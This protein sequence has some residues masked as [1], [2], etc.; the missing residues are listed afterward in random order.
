MQITRVMAVKIVFNS[1]RIACTDLRAVAY[2]HEVALTM[3]SPRKHASGS[4]ELDLVKASGAIILAALEGSAWC[5]RRAAG[6]L[7]SLG[8]YGNLKLKIPEKLIIIKKYRLGQ[9]N[10]CTYWPRP[11]NPHVAERRASWGENRRAITKISE[12]SP[13]QPSCKPQ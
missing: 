6:R 1:T 3:D 9:I 8:T 11:S 13:R 10:R 12:N 7:P 5:T 4:V 2:D